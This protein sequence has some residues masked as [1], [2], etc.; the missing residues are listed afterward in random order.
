[1][2]CRAWRKD[3]FLRTVLQH[4]TPEENYLEGDARIFSMK[5]ERMAEKGLKQKQ[6]R[7]SYM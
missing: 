1:M 3:D 2:G 5:G 7:S 4:P 6:G